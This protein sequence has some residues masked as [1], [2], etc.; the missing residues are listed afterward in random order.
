MRGHLLVAPFCLFIRAPGTPTSGRALRERS[1][2][3]ER[4]VC[5]V[6]ITYPG[7]SPC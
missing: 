5:P 7:E 3:P 4:D 2:D 1:E 6:R